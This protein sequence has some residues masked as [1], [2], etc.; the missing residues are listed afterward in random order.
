M[1]NEDRNL[2]R[3]S[4]I[5]SSGTRCERVV[6]REGELCYSHDPRYKE[7]R[8]ATASKAGKLSRKSNPIEEVVGLR[9]RLD[10]ILS[11][12]LEG[13]LSTACGQ[14]AATIIGVALKSF[15]VEKRQKEFIEIEKR[16]AEVEKA[17]A[18]KSNPVDNDGYSFGGGRWAR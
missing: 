8:K 6:S 4:G 12:V 2:L 5:T 1:N 16:L 9:A 10:E 3:C 15:E 7:G 13:D 18:R 11:D 14:V 17:Y